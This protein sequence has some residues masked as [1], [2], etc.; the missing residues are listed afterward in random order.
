MTNNDNEDNPRNNKD[1]ENKEENEPGPSPQSQINDERCHW[2]DVDMS[3]D[4]EDHG[5]KTQ[6]K[7]QAQQKKSR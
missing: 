2:L 5:N 1:T 3:V 4:N 6:S 7:K